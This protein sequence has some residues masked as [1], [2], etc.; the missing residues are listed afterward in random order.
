MD[1]IPSGAKE[2]DEEGPVLL[3]AQCMGTIAAH[4][5]L[6]SMTKENI[7][8]ALVTFSPP[9]PNPNEVIQILGCFQNGVPAFVSLTTPVDVD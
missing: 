2:K 1:N 9:L 6:L 8:T 3:I 7:N 5:A 4:Q